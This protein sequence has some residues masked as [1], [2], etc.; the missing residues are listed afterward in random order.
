MGSAMH[1]PYS[2]S[3]SSL[4]A[5]E[6]PSSRIVSVMLSQS[7]SHIHLSCRSLAAIGSKSQKVRLQEDEKTV[8]LQVGKSVFDGAPRN[9]RTELWMSSLQ[10]KGIGVAASQKYEDMLLS[11][12]EQLQS[13]H[14]TYVL[15][16]Q[17]YCS[18][19][20]TTSSVLQYS[21][22][23]VGNCSKMTSATHNGTA[24]NIQVDRLAGAIAQPVNMHSACRSLALTSQAPRT[25]QTT[26]CRPW[27]AGFHASTHVLARFLLKRSFDT[28]SDLV[29]HTLLPALQPVGAEAPACPHVTSPIFDCSVANALS[30]TPCTPCCYCCC[31]RCCSLLVVRHQTT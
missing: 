18:Q 14:T 12:S 16:C 9:M 6:L 17:H 4:A 27:L 24:C 28:A 21:S 2:T 8:T 20:I 26:G 23:Q 30:C 29:L 3:N 11:V 22:Q 5:A 19:Q 25:C 15:C 1:I 13:A 31:C 10:R 7:A